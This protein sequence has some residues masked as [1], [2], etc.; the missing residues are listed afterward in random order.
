MLSSAKF[1]HDSI[2][3]PN[4]KFNFSVALDWRIDILDEYSYPWSKY[5]LCFLFSPRNFCILLYSTALNK[6]GAIP[7]LRSY[8][9]IDADQFQ[10]ACSPKVTGSNSPRNFTFALPASYDASYTRYLI[11]SGYNAEMK[12]KMFFKATLG[13]QTSTSQSVELRA[14]SSINMVLLS[15]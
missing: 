12:D 13:S 14:D 8:A 3:S 7:L 10:L 5:A 2:I 6:G 15:I 1:L 11:L 9:L 4:S